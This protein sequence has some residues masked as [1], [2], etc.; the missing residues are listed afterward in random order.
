MV[1]YTP[2]LEEIYILMYTRVPQNIN[3][4][5]LFPIEIVSEKFSVDKPLLGTFIPRS[6]GVSIRLSVHHSVIHLKK[7]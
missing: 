7:I 1:T 6:V 4:F 5:V 3:S 2:Y